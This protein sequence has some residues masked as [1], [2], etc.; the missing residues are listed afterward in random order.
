MAGHVKKNSI[1]VEWNSVSNSIR[2]CSYASYFRL[3][4]LNM[5]NKQNVCKNLFERQNESLSRGKY[6]KV[7]ISE[8]G[9]RQFF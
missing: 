8:T 3:R 6:P 5:K 2:D 4:R 1:G 9:T 7:E